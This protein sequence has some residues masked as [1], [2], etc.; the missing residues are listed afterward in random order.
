[1]PSGQ[2]RVNRQEERE[3]QRIAR[4][5]VEEDRLDEKKKK[6]RRGEG[7]EEERTGGRPGG[8]GSQEGEVAARDQPLVIFLC[9]SR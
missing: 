2:V 1:M 8:T 4:K 5:I 7:R 9:R 6:A 3:N